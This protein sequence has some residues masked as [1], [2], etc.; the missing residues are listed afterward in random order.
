MHERLGKDWLSRPAAW[1]FSPSQRR[2]GLTWHQLPCA[3][4][5]F[6]GFKNNI[7]SLLPLKFK[8]YTTI[9]PSYSRILG[10]PVLWET[11][12][13]N[14]AAWWP[15]IPKRLVPDKTCRPKLTWASWQY[16][17]RTLI[18]WCGRITTLPTCLHQGKGVEKPVLGV[19]LTQLFI[20]FQPGF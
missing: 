8:A 3:L 7:T 16:F 20:I 14:S 9:N 10:S 4:L 6:L 19:S 13:L 12:N 2:S 15:A 18:D 17:T 1:A 11:Q 5:L